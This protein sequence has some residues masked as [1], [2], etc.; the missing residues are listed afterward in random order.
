MAAFDWKLVGLDRMHVNIGLM[1]EQENPGPG[2]SVQ[3]YTV[4][5]GRTKTTGQLHYILH[6]RFDPINQIYLTENAEENLKHLQ[7]YSETA[8]IINS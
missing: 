5:C 1:P 2:F 6:I 7:N 8:A 3:F 4:E